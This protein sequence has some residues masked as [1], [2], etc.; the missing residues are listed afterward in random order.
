MN[1]QTERLENHTARLTVEVPAERLEAAKKR[2]A[3]KL[4]SRYKIPGFRQ[5]KA[6]YNVV[7]KY[8]GEAN[9]I[10]EAVEMLGNEIY[11]EA[12][13]QGDLN[14]YGPGSI[15]DVKL[16]PLTYTYTV[17]LQAEVELGDYRSVRVD[18]A[19]KVIGDSDVD[20]AL[21]QVRRQRAVVTPSTEAAKLGD[22]VTVDIHSEFADGDDAP[23]EDEAEEADAESSAEGAEASAEDKPKREAGKIYKGDPFMHEHGTK[24]DLEAGKTTVLLGFAEALVGAELNQTL[25][26]DLSIPAEDEDYIEGARGRQVHFSVTVNAIE[27]VQL[28]EMDDA[29]AAQLTANENPPLTLEQLRE[30]VRENLKVEAENQYTEQYTEAVL[31]KIIEGAQMQYPPKMVENRI[32]EQLAELET[33]F[34]NDYKISL[35]QYREITGITEDAMREQMRP[36][37]EKWVRRSLV[38]GE[39]LTKENVHLHNEE[40]DAVINSS[41]ARMDKSDSKSIKRMRSNEQR[42][43]VANYILY[44]RVMFRLMQIGKGE[45][46]VDDHDH[47]H[48]AADESENQ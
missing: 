25:E 13:Q 47:D 4:S 41:I 40:I 22:R 5:G 35:E 28:P 12:I 30:R 38:L 29:L 31:T 15:D 11:A 43:N 16:D 34:K 6:P 20:E 32:D 27:S 8:L 14:P 21:E 23:A 18:Y 9:V 39:L 3:Q 17:S 1:I 45:T 42:N 48:E 2:A 10:E 37:A 36:D 26:F 7:L 33:R 19:P 46:L 44:N 24:I